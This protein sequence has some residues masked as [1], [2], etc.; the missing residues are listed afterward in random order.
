MNAIGP[1]PLPT[2]NLYKFYA[3]TGV[4]VILLTL[5]TAW[6]LSDDVGNSNL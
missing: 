2:D 5:Y 3:L 4:A 1:L 6:R